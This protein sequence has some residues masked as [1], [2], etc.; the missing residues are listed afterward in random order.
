MSYTIKHM[1]IGGIL[2][3]AIS[4]VKD[5]FVL[6]FTIM[7]FGLIPVLLAQEFLKLAVTPELPPNPTMQDYMRV[8]QQQNAYWPWFMA[9]NVLYFLIVIPI[10][11]AAV[12]QSVARVY[13]GQSITAVEALKH[14]VR[15]LLPL[16]GTTILMYLAIWGGFLLL[17]IPGIYFAIWFGLSQHV[18]VLE[19]L[20]GPK[21][22][23]RS[24]KLVH[25]DRGKFLALG[26][27]AGIITF[28]LVI[29]TQMI[30]QPHVRAVASALVQAVATML[31]T[32]AFVVFYFSC[33]CNVENFDLHYLAESIGAQPPEIGTNPAMARGT[34]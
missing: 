11:N 12:I 22:L 17:I 32:A 7:L 21:A 13:L 23:G 34:M 8:Q 16:I 4:I 10:T 26:L 31:A 33:R 28:M 29:G 5:N 27:I 14:G 2:D 3:Q 30:P 9:I 6:L 25:K 19:G 24:K 1:G 18:V 15:R 20:A